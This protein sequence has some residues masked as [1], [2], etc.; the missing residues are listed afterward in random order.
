LL[1]N[2]TAIQAQELPPLRTLVNDI[3]N[4]PIKKLKML[5]DDAQEFAS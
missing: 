1:R 4:E 3:L 5:F 2:S